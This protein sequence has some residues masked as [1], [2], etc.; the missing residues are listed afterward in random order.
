M[1]L[2]FIEGDIKER[3]EV[4]R[5]RL[6]MLLKSS[7]NST[8][9]LVSVNKETNW[10]FIIVIF[11]LDTFTLDNMAI[12]PIQINTW[13]GVVTESLPQSEWCGHI[14]RGC[15]DQVGGKDKYLPVAAASVPP[16]PRC[17]GPPYTWA[18][19]TRW[20]RSPGSA[21]VLGSCPP[22]PAWRRLVREQKGVRSGSIVVALCW[23]CWPDSQRNQDF[24]VLKHSQSNCQM[25]DLQKKK[26]VQ[27]WE[28]KFDGV[29]LLLIWPWWL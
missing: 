20:R 15:V 10:S 9:L 13:R 29:I 16:G 4:T 11:L 2:R 7:R 26:Q 27:G 19:W 17:G 8:P 21:E 22:P 24:K 3:E 1:E 28:P 14:I 6:T 5:T 25:I 12:K 23:A 18:C